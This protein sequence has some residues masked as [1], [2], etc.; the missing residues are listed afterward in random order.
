MPQDI[1]VDAGLAVLADPATIEPSLIW[2][3]AWGRGA[4]S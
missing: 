3:T 1:D 2:Y 4:P